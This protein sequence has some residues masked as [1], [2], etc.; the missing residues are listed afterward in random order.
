MNGI[1][2]S[3]SAFD[4]FGGGEVFEPPVFAALSSGCRFRGCVAVPGVRAAAAVPGCN[5]AAWGAGTAMVAEEIISEAVLQE[6]LELQQ[7]LQGS[8]ASVLERAGIKVPGTES[9]VEAPG[10]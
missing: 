7:T 10:R 4:P 9:L 1:V 5:V 2:G 6:A 8:I 3:T